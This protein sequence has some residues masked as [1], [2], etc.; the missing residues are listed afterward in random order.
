MIIDTN[1]KYKSASS[2]MDFMS[3]LVTTRLQD[4][5]KID[6]GQQL[7]IRE[8]CLNVETMIGEVYMVTTNGL[9]SVVTYMVGDFGYFDQDVYIMER[10]FEPDTIDDETCQKAEE[11]VV[12]KFTSNHDGTYSLKELRFNL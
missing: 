3:D 2:I 12:A 4:G 6:F 1:K 7:S 11:K 5:Y 9:E 8:C 10:H